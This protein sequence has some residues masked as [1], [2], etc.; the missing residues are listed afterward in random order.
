MVENVKL[1]I[2][3]SL[4]EFSTDPQILYTYQVTDVTNPTVVK[5]SFSKTITIDGT[6]T[7]NDIFGHYWNLERYLLNGGAGG[8]YYNSSKKAP[9]QLFIGS[10]L[11]EDGYCKLDSIIKNGDDIKYN[12]T[13]YGGLGDFFFN[14]STSDDGDEKKLSDLS[15][16]PSGGTDEFDFTANIDTVHE[17]WNALE[18]GTSGKWQYINFMPAYN[19]K[20][21]DFDTDKVILNL[22]G[23]TLA[24][25]V[26]ADGTR[27]T[28][29]QNFSIGTLPS[30]MTEWDV[31]DLRSYL[32]RPCIRMKEIVNAC[33]KPENNGGYTV[34][35]DPDFFTS[36]N[37]YWEKTW[38]TLPM[39]SN[40]EYANQEQ[41]LDGAVLQTLPT[42]GESSGLMY[43]DMRF[44]LGEL[45]PNISYV[46]VK[47]TLKAT[48]AMP[49]YNYTS[50]VWFWNW[51]GDDYHTGS[52][53]L[54]SLFCQLVAV[55]GETVVGASEV[56][57]LT[58]P[59]RHN[60]KLY[61]GHNGHYPESSEYDA[62][63]GRRKMGNGSKYIPYL[64]MPIYSILGKFDSTNGFVREISHT[65]SSSTYDSTP[66][67]LDFHISNI[68]TTI[69]GLK[70]VYYWGATADKVR[71]FEYA[72]SL[73]S[74]TTEDSWIFEYAPTHGAPDAEDYNSTIVD[75]N[76]NAVMGESLGRTGTKVNKQL[77]LNTESSPCDYLL[78]Y[79]KM[80]GL[81]FTKE[82]GNKTINILT[83]KTYYNRTDVV[84][85]EEMIDDSKQQDIKPIMFKSKW[86]QFLQDKDETDLQQ[87][88][89]TAKG[90]EY[91]SKV[92]D[93]GYEFG[94]EK[95]D[96]LKD[97][98]I[99]AG[100]EALEKSRWF[101]AYNNDDT[102]RPWMNVGL[103]YTLW[104]GDD[105]YE[106][107]AGIGSSGNILPI[108]E[109]DGMK[110]YDIF[111]KVQ[112]H[113]SDGS[114]TDGNNCLVFFSG[115]KDVVNGRG[116]PLTYILSDDTVY[117]TDMNEGTPCW[118]FSKYEYAGNKRI[119][120][121]L[122]SI[123]VF[124]RYLTDSGSGTIEQS[125]DFGSTQELYVPTYSLSDDVNIYH[126]YWRTYLEDL[127]N[128]N[129][130]Q[131]TAF[132]KFN[133]N[134]GSDWLRRFYWF[135]NSIWII[136][137]I[138]DWNPTSRE[139]CKVEFIK[140]QDIAD[141]TSVTPEPLPKLKLVSNSYNVPA[142]G[143]SITLT[144][145]TAE[146][147]HWTITHTGFG[148][149]TLSR[150]GGEG[151][152]NITAT[153]NPNTRGEPF[154]FQITANRDNFTYRSS[155]NITQDYDG[156]V[157]VTAT[158]SNIIV[159]ATG[160][161][162][163]IDFT[164]FNQGQYYINAASAHTTA[165][166]CIFTADTST[167]RTENKATL[168]F[169]P[170][171]GSTVLSNTCHFYVSTMRT[172]YCEVGIDQLPLEVDFE[173][174]GSTVT[175]PFEN[176]SGATFTNVPY[177]LNVV[178]NGDGTYDLVSVENTG[179][180]RGGKVTVSLNNTSADFDVIQSSGQ[181][182]KVTP[183]A[184][185]YDSSGGTQVLTVSIDNA[186]QVV[187]YPAWVS[188][189]ALSGSTSGTIDVTAIPNSGGER[190]GTLAVY[191]TVTHQAYQVYV[192]QSASS[193]E[194]LA[195]SPSRLTFPASGGTILLTIISNTDWTIA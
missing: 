110:Y 115:F 175:L 38:L 24:K 127:F 91:G 35:L 108:N 105:E 144:V 26:V 46:N 109:D 69:T 134:P 103:K 180:E 89:L 90:V 52:W 176:A 170:N 154:T 122:T 36:T 32:Q 76:V 10:D 92:L 63:T 166:Y 93:T 150:D 189:S 75:H 152:M 96:L 86:Y 6:P 87:R 129:T 169:E 163:E 137:K 146:D 114:P 17:A 82:V 165:G 2:N 151:T 18:N 140:V 177:W 184:L 187:G 141:Y 119:C 77:L 145:I 37:P 70:M 101:T 53:C 33:C 100:I 116:N 182:G 68:N 55:N 30:E 27:Y 128:V 45:P 138:I 20:P 16:T 148:D 126:S 135:R 95:E 194:V 83:R 193:G 47:T 190:T 57:N 160:G 99:K 43:Q 94:A 168:R 172:V 131:M 39:V 195:V 162:V 22:S 61:Y 143:G 104:N 71:R 74:K 98:C 155:V 167:K 14:L 117:Q 23:T 64:D 73:L 185:M 158:P 171:T 56:Y 191:D 15:Y 159:P 125:L 9:F 156:G 40:L 181:Q 123:P 25:D 161:T 81:H 179:S 80:F 173:Q 5:N 49:W 121:K 113:D 51:N 79:C 164:W 84:D 85:L 192:T 118:L 183:G 107:N 67:V 41:I 42:T 12:I 97:N 28:S 44:D 58:T 48:V 88:Y 147:V 136:N 19:G 29:K 188:V 21:D 34:N 106:H 142:S 149:I 102:L 31:R 72:E 65:S 133:D 130:K 11:Y 54:G 124:E 174:T 186:W 3:N 66:Y 13:L 178:D 112:F 62:Q 139:T 120:Y 7:N 157:S 111:P 1:Y 60:G 132:V 50:Y 153:F 78:S 4:V 59:I 8:A